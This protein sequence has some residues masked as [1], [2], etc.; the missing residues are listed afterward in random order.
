MFRVNSLWCWFS[1]SLMFLVASASFVAAQDQADEK[2]KAEKK[3]ADKTSASRLRAVRE[4]MGQITMKSTV[5]DE[6]QPLELTR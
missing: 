6:P 5:G 3:I 1:L 2:E 4:I